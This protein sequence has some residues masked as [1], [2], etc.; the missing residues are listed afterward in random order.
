MW[1]V[2]QECE[3]CGKEAIPAERSWNGIDRIDNE[4]GYVYGNCAPCCW[5][6]NKAKG[7]RTAMEFIDMC[8]RV[9]EKW[10]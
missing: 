9:A 1:L 6:C 8:T 4:K 10:K 5:G 7:K 3:Y 2:Q